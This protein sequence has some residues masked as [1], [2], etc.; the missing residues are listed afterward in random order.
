MNNPI[1]LLLTVI[2]V[3]LSG[4]SATEAIYSNSKLFKQLDGS[5]ITFTGR[6]IP[7]INK[8]PDVSGGTG[9]MYEIRMPY[10]KAVS[11]LGEHLENSQNP[12]QLL[13]EK[14]LEILKS[15][16]NMKPLSDAI[17]VYTN[18]ENISDFMGRPAVDLKRTRSNARFIL[19]TSVSIIPTQGPAKWSKIGLI[20]RVYIAIH[21]L[22]TK[23]RVL[24]IRTV[25]QA[26][27]EHNW[28]TIDELLSNS[29][30]GIDSQL[31]QA[32]SKAANYLKQ[33]LRKHS[34]PSVSGHER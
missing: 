12:N 9:L 28:L 11:A 4:C 16:R 3:I 20:V 10:E 23:E 32:L 22:E 30:K 1:K 13:A 33:E 19:D 14:I 17:V 8:T 24:K 27:K 15:D 7:E 6:D 26:P 18:K 2:S 34:Q 29:E 25:W 31:D 21:D 5:S